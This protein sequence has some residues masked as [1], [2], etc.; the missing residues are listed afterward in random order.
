MIEWIR[1]E[2]APK[3]GRWLVC[4]VAN[5][6]PC[7]A[8][9]DRDRWV[10]VE[11]WLSKDRE[12]Y[13]YRPD[14]FCYLPYFGMEDDRGDRGLDAPSAPAVV[15]SKYLEALRKQKESKRNG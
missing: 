8:H 5:C 13:I 15:D 9:W 2:E 10:T 14:W 7:V 12:A 4:R 1:I 6:L 11:D 3:D